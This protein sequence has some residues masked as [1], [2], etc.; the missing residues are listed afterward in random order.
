MG[1]IEDADDSACRLLG[2]SHD[3]MRELHGSQL[4]PPGER[5]AVAVSLD[6]M[7]RGEIDQRRGRLVRKDGTVLEVDVSAEWL[8]D[9]R[10]ALV[11]RP[12]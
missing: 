5:P 4:V 12:V 1:R 7:R 9:D 6:R 11:V 2:Y 10:L 8:S 3:E